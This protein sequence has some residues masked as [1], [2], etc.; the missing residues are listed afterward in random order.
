MHDAIGLPIWATIPASQIVPTMINQGRTVVAGKPR[1][2]VGKAMFEI[3]RMLDKKM[4]A[5][6]AGAKTSD[7]RYGTFAKD[8]KGGRD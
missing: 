3:A 7:P 6:S 4:A 2:K 8:S 1:H 5:K